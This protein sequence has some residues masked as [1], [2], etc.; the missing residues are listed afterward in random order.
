MKLVSC[1]FNETIPQTTRLDWLVVLPA[2]CCGVCACVLAR[3]CWVLRGTR[4][5]P[6]TDLSGASCAI[7]AEKNQI[8]HTSRK[9]T[10]ARA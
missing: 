8:M 10:D 3:V 6:T 4:E 9:Q 1:E 7:G 2:A 5:L